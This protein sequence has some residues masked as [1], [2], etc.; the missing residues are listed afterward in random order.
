[1][2]Q[3]FNSSQLSCICL[4]ERYGLLVTTYSNLVTHTQAAPTPVNISCVGWLVGLVVMSLLTFWKHPPLFYFSI[5]TSSEGGQALHHGGLH[6][7]I[8]H[9]PAVRSSLSKVIFTL[10]LTRRALGRLGTSLCLSVFISAVGMARG[11]T[12]Q[13]CGGDVTSYMQ[14]AT[15][16]LGR[17]LGSSRWMSSGFHSL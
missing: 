15:A 9:N 14:R 16:G 11:F 8:P 4:N 5:L 2:K 7:P 10:A 17:H 3:R 12:L 6:H 1:M 13:G